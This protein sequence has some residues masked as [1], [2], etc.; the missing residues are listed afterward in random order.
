MM[1]DYNMRNSGASV[2]DIVENALDKRTGG[3]VVGNVEATEFKSDEAATDILKTKDASLS[4]DV[5]KL[6]NANIDNLGGNTLPTADPGI[7]G[8][9]WN[10]AGT[11]KVSV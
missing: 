10:D 4:I 6:C 3:I 5:T 1:A 8:R 11:L 7:P 9:L 2:D